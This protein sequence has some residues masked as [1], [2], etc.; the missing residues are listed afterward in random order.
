MRATSSDGTDT[1]TG[2]PRIF[3]PARIEV[4]KGLRLDSP[5]MLT[6]L[7]ALSFERDY[8]GDIVKLSAVPAPVPAPLRSSAMRRAPKRSDARR[9]R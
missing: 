2:E 7:L 3:M 5:E 1:K 6:I 9:A 4:P 8:D